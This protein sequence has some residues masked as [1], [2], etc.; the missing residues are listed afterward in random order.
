MCFLTNP[1]FFI[2]FP[3]KYWK[4]L[5]FPLYFINFFII[6]IED[7]IERP[8]K[9][10]KRHK[11]QADRSDN[12]Q[13]FNSNHHRVL[14]TV[15]Q[16]PQ[17]QSNKST[18]HKS[19]S[20]KHIRGP[21]L[22]QQLTT[23]MPTTIRGYNENMHF[24]VKTCRWE[25]NNEDLRR[26]DS[27]GYGPSYGIYNNSINH[28]GNFGHSPHPSTIGNG[29]KTPGL[30]A[31]I[32]PNEIK[33]VGDMVFD[34]ARM[35]WIS[36]REDE[37]E[38]PFEGLD[39]MDGPMGVF[40]SSNRSYY[41]DFTNTQENHHIQQQELYEEE[42]EEY[43]DDDDGVFTDGFDEEFDFD[44]LHPNMY[45]T[46]THTFNHN[47][48]NYSFPDR[49]MYLGQLP[50]SRSQS[51]PKSRRQ[52]MHNIYS[53]DGRA[54]SSMYE[55]AST[56]SSTTSFQVDNPI[57]STDFQT[58]SPTRKYRSMRQEPQRQHGDFVVGKEF[59]LKEET[60]KKLKQYQDRW[61]H[62]VGGWFP[63]GKNDDTDK[64]YLWELRRMVMK[65]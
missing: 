27:A 44:E 6:I 51:R 54:V 34:P 37:E 15:N 49:K 45:S 50:R 13:R 20:S 36:I 25:G 19:H 1:L 61:R 42:E 48:E 2:L 12:Y 23:P 56:A 38:D 14:N 33:V 9:T 7:H 18:S 5:G 10:I 53:N 24:D 22:I 29:G 4:S 30:I 57:T 64:K 55:L 3:F 52:Q 26:F 35:C 60:Q 58:T 16:Y 31:F 17:R 32:S 8:I 41:L 47:P 28:H 46:N 65:Q 62:R 63:P 11:Q 43:G 39:D 40:K 21:R 59:V